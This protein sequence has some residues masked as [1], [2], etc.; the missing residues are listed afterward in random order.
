LALMA[1]VGPGYRWGGGR[2]A[3]SEECLT[4]SLAG[5]RVATAEGRPC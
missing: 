2:V 3:S 4:D 5:G 1:C